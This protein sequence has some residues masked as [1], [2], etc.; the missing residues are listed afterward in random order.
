MYYGGSGSF[1]G[2]VSPYA[3]NNPG[4]ESSYSPTAPGGSPYSSNTPFLASMLGWPAYWWLQANWYYVAAV[5][6][7]AVIAI[8]FMAT[9]RA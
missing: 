8:V 6:A 4:N 7:V 1:H 3:F 2:T 9:R 5:V